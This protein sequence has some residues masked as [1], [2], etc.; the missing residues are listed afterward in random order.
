MYVWEKQ[1]TKSFCN[2]SIR[3]HHSLCG[4]KVAVMSMGYYCYCA[5]RTF[6]G[7]TK[8]G[9]R[10]GNPRKGFKKGKK[11]KSVGYFHASKLSKLAFLSSFINEEIHALEGLLSLFQHLK[12][13]CFRGL[14]PSP[15]PRGDPG[16]LLG[17]L[18]PGP[19]RLL[20]P[21]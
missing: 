5:C 21:L 1:C 6:R 11:K 15:P 8:R 10:G 4:L 17:V 20:L 7:S 2:A 19:P 13:I 9:G 14:H 16:P 12:D 3:Q 18:P